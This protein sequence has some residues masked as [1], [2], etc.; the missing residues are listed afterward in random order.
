V[1]LHRGNAAE[2]AVAQA[3]AAY[4]EPPRVHVEAG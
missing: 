2:G 1:L 4:T 3:Y